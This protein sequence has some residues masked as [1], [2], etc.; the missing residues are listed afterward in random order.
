[1]L[2]WHLSE[3]LGSRIWNV[4][5][6]VLTRAAHSEI[7]RLYV[8]EGC[9]GPTALGHGVEHHGLLSSSEARATHRGPAL[10][11]LGMQLAEYA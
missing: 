8:K 7:Q 9:K 10:A 11:D 5:K 4:L 6:N 1:M 2:R 3:A